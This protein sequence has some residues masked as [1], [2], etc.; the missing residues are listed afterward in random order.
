VASEG[1]A[2]ERSRPGDDRARCV[3]QIRRIEERTEVRT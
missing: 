2:F 3:P 1:M